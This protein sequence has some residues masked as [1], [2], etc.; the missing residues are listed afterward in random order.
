LFWALRVVDSPSAGFQGMREKTGSEAAE[1]ER[2]DEG[3]EIASAMARALRRRGAF[4]NWQLAL[5]AETIQI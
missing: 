4:N 1:P 3:C 5:V 2:I